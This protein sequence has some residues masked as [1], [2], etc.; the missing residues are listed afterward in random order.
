[1][2]PPTRT[3]LQ[4]RSG[5]YI[6]FEDPNPD[7]IILEDI[8]HALALM[9][10]F[11]GHTP[12]P[13]SVAQHSV[14]ASLVAPPGLRLEALMHDAQEAYVIDL[15]SP[16]KRLLPGYREVEQRVEAVIRKKFELPEVFNPIVKEIDTRMLV[17]EAKAFGLS[18]WSSIGVEPYLELSIRP[19]SWN[20]AKGAFLDRYEFLTGTR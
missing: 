6:N 13:Y 1:M 11:A 15:P 7:T 18:W 12:F 4:T 10:R 20:H 5:H 3:Y 8:A 19:W 17:T 9:N 2:N 16:L 14:L